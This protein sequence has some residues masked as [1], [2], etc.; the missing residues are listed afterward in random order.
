MFYESIVIDEGEKPS[1]EELLSRP[2]LQKYM[3][4][5]GRRGDVALVAEH[6]DKKV[7]AAW[8]RLFGDSEKGYGFVAE[9][10][11]EISIAITENYRG[12]GIGRNLMTQLIYKAKSEGFSAL[13]LSVSRLNQTAVSLYNQLGFEKVA[14]DSTSDTMLLVFESCK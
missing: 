9:T 1:K 3:H 13:S 8:F 2:E 6:N 7:G 14:E 12:K 11:P 10:I 4:N 5:W